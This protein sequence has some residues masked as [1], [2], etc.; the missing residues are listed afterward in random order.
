MEDLEVLGLSISTLVLEGQLR[1]EILTLMTSLRCSSQA[2]V[3]VWEAHDL[4]TKILT[5]FPI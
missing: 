3:E 5:S 2:E 1:E 4:A